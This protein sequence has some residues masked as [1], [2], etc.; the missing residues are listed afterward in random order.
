MLRIYVY[1]NLH[2]Y[3]T[4]VLYAVKYLCWTLKIQPVPQNVFLKILAKW[5]SVLLQLSQLMVHHLVAV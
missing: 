2:R 5:I 3:K 1:I 4:R